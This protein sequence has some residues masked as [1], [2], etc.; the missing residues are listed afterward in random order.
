MK[1]IPSIVKKI[2][3]DTL[4]PNG[5]FEIKR[6][7]AVMAFNFSILYAFTPLLYPKFIVLEFVFFALITFC[8][9]V[10]GI[11]DYFKSRGKD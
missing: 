6:M 7:L 4:A 1:K 8:A 10:I 2:I 3:L 9:S 5:R 11:K